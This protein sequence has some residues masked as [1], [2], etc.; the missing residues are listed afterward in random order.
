MNHYILKSKNQNNQVKRLLLRIKM[1]K[2]VTVHDHK[3]VKILITTLK[4]YNKSP[5]PT[6]NIHYCMQVNQYNNKSI[7]NRIH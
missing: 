1:N 2:N 3:T 6:I 7:K 4:I 5:I